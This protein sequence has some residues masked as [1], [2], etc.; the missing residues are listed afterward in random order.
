MKPRTF[1]H[2]WTAT[3]A[4]LAFAAG[5]LLFAFPAQSAKA[6]AVTLPGGVSAEELAAYWR[7]DE[8]SGTY[9]ADSSG[10][11]RHMTL[12]NGSA[13]QWRG[14][15]P[16][17]GT[18][19]FQ[20][21]G[22]SAFLMMGDNT[23]NETDT[24]G[25][26]WINTEY[27]A[28]GKTQRVEDDQSLTI[29]FFVRIDDIVYDPDLPETN[30][31]NLLF[32]NEGLAVGIAG[33]IEGA[34]LNA[35]H[36]KSTGNLDVGSYDPDYANQWMFCGIKGTGGIMGGTD[37]V[38][39]P[40]N[41]NDKFGG[42]WVMA[43]YV[44]DDSF[45]RGTND[46][47][48]YLNGAAVRSESL[49]LTEGTAKSLGNQFNAFC[50]GGWKGESPGQVGANRG[51]HGS[52]SEFMVFTRAL[53]AGEVAAL[54]AGYGAEK[55]V[56]P[57]DEEAVTVTLD[58]TVVSSL[59]VGATLQLTATV[60]PASLENKAVTWKTSDAAIAVVDADGKVTAKKAGAVMITAVSAVD[61]TKSAACAINV[62]AA[63]GGGCG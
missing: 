21:D 39:S 45:E 1:L 23:F 11:A 40:N 15:G 19:S 32:G 4:L 33:S 3:L 58:K 30:G 59:A 43:T 51:F 57:A 31:F 41:V 54:A 14:D 29:S 47:T 8:T 17:D 5:G 55:P 28:D 16:A 13:A 24:G 56:G 63:T 25:N 10:N 20:F 36:F 52:M 27:H 9:A 53:E 2:R 49:S 7:F 34:I 48:F 46:F 6:D 35:E 26:Y 38:V 12:L 62:T 18:R 42:E 22:N 61:G 60:G 44:I 50:V 37:K